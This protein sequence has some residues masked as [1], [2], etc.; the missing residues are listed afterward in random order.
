ML[1]LCILAATI[2]FYL[3]QDKPCLK[4]TNLRNIIDLLV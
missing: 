2:L 4:D 3:R 1:Y